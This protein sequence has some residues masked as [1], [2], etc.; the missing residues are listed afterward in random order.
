[1]ADGQKPQSS[2]EPTIADLVPQSSMPGKNSPMRQLRTPQLQ[3]CDDSLRDSGMVQQMVLPSPQQATPVHT[4]KLLQMQ[5]Q[6]SQPQLVQPSVQQSAQQSIQQPGQIQ[7]AGCAQRVMSTSL[8]QVRH[9]NWPPVP[10]GSASPPKQSASPVVPGSPQKIPAAALARWEGRAAPM[11]RTSG[12]CL[13]PGPSCSSQTPQALQSCAA[14]SRPRSTSLRKRLEL[15]GHVSRER[16][17]WLP[18]P[19]P[20][21]SPARRTSGQ[22]PGGS[23]SPRKIPASALAPWQQTVGNPSSPRRSPSQAT[24]Q[25]LSEPVQVRVEEQS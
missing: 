9:Q 19:A 15:Q 21:A 14:D 20:P 16:Q 3:G 7:P 13:I 22:L 17:N 23:K 5:Q 25:H 1:V 8:L 24:M 10:G 4:P 11:P 18:R 2:S 12:S 6:P